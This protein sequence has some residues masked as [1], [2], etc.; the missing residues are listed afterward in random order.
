MKA[1]KRSI[2]DRYRRSDDGR[3]VIDITADRIED[4][5]NDFDK[6]TPYS[7]KELDKDFSAYLIDCVREIGKHPFVI[8]INLDKPPEADRWQQAIEGIRNYFVYLKML[9]I[10]E[11]KGF[12]RT[13]AI[14]LALGIGVMILSIWINRT[15]QDHSGLVSNVFVEGLTVAAW[16]L[17]WESLATFLIQWPP[18]H[19]EIRWYEKIT[20]AP[21]RYHCLKA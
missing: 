9:K 19:K 4:I 14:L 3:I 8:Q 11:M 21:I 5:F 17:M 20:D 12:F 18:E 10:R 16:V 15:F 6:T 7:K 2:L 13:S 1:T